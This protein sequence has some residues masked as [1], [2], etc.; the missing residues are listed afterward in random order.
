MFIPNRLKDV[1]SELENG[2]P[3]SDIDWNRIGL[4]QT[5]D[6]VIAGREFVEE[7]AAREEAEDE[8]IRTEWL[9]EPPVSE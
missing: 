1:R 3:V 8:W 6:M 2:R 9:G 5:L 7:A 4:L